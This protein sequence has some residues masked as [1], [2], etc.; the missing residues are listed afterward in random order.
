MQKFNLDFLYSP[1]FWQLF[2]VGLTTGLNIPLPNNPWVQGL[3]V[4]VGIWLGGSVVVRTVD[5]VTEVKPISTT[6]IEDVGGKTV[7]TSPAPPPLDP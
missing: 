2:L 4:A 7:T 5:R 6:T 3:A 1:R